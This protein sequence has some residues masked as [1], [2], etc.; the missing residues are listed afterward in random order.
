MHKSVAADLQTAV[1]G[2][3]L[4]T[5]QRTTLPAEWCA[6]VKETR[7]DTEALVLVVRCA[8][9][10][11]TGRMVDVAKMRGAYGRLCVKHSLPTFHHVRLMILIA[12]D[13]L[14]TDQTDEFIRHA[15]EY[16]LELRM[17]SEAENHRLWRNVLQENWPRFAKGCK[18]KTSAGIPS[19]TGT[20]ELVAFS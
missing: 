2:L 18:D 6:Q 16:A 3:D 14:G 17:W 7:K 19:L 8:M 12:E 20:Q 10:N 1:V 9:G 11:I 5:K 15:A 4:K 13:L